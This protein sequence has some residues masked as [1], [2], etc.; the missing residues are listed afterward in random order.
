MATSNVVGMVTR[1]RLKQPAAK[2][3]YWN[4][5]HRLS[6]RSRVR[7]K[8]EKGEALSY[9]IVDYVW[10]VTHV[11]SKVSIVKKQMMKLRNT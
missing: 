7:L 5:V 6:E 4:K 8:L 10:T 2:I 3:P 9:D 11:Q 1:I